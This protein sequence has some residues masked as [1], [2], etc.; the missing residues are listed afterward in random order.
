MTLPDEE[1][2][3]LIYAREFLQSLLDPRKT[4]KVPRKIRE[5]ARQRL[6][7]YP[8]DYRINELYGIENGNW[9]LYTICEECMGRGLIIKDKMQSICLSCMGKGNKRV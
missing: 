5:E 4:P 6:R 9:G 7:H 1:R 3:S 8:G 2:R